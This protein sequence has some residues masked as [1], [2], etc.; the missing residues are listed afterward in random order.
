MKRSVFIVVLLLSA[1]GCSAEFPISLIPDAS[2]VDAFVP[3]D[4]APPVDAFVP[5]DGAPPV[6]AL[7][8]ATVDECGDGSI[9]GGEQCDD[10]NTDDHDGCSASCQ[11]EAGWDCTG[12]PSQCVSDC[13]DGILVGTEEC[14]DGNSTDGDGCSASCEAECANGSTTD[15]NYAGQTLD[16]ASAFVD[17]APPTGFIQCAGF[18]NTA[19]NDVGPHW[20]ANCLGVAAVL[21]IRY[22]DTSSTP[23]VLLGD[24]TLS[25]AAAGTYTTQ[26]FSATN[27]AGTLGVKEADGVTF[28]MDDPA[29]GTLSS[30][31]CQVGPTSRHFQ[32]TDF[33]FANQANDRVLVAS[34]NSKTDDGAAIQTDDEELALV[35][36][37][38]GQCPNL[39]LNALTELAIAIFVEK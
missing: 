35:E 27:H 39:N 7:V 26:S 15:C 8:D 11:V 6:D 3:E 25:P 28:L 10:W 19:A 22:Y 4:S 38:F 24:A 20:D 1:Q 13:G 21:R 36:R 29:G 12:E 17:P 14:D 18:V 30:F 2:T 31:E 9:L 32:A 16:P 33:Y 5:E 34:G 23:W 37:A